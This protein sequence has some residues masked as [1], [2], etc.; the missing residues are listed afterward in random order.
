MGVKKVIAGAIGGRA[1]N[2]SVLK[3]SVTFVGM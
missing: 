1:Y 2:I 3:S